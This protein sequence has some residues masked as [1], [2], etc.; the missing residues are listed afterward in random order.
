MEPLL[1][2]INTVVPLILLTLLGYFLRRVK[3][4]SEHTAKEINKV[5]FHVFLPIILFVSVYEVDSLS[6]INWGVSVFSV[7]GLLLSFSIGIIIAALFTPDKRQ[8][9]VV[10]QCLSRTNFTLLGLPLAI[11]LFGASGGQEASVLSLFAVPLG[12]ILAVIAFRMYSDSSGKKLSS[13]LLDIAKNPMIIGIVL[14]FASL[15]IRAV[16]ER[17]GIDF[18]LRD[19]QFFYKALSTAGSITSPL[20]LISLGALFTFSASREYS[21]QIILATLFRVAIIPAIALPVAYLF[22][23]SFHGA[24]FAALIALFASPAAVSSAVLAAEMGGDADLGGQ[25][26]VWTTLVS[27][28]TIFLF[29]TIFRALGAL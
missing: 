6:S 3:L 4:L 10:V 15:C 9:G 25:L 24:P 29:V 7:T 21:K 22:F 19:I 5:I 20:A 12:N 18:R 1:F 2:A 13:V 28:L 8:K 27:A 23:P 17:V 26:V 14:G 11:S 16:F